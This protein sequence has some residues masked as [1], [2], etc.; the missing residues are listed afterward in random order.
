MGIL[1][2]TPDSF[3][4]GGKYYS[5]EDAFMHAAELE[6]EGADII[7][8]GGESSRP[9]AVPVCAQEEI[10]RILPVLIRIKKNLNIKVS[11]DTVKAE[12]AEHC[13]NEGADIINDISG[14]M[15]DKKMPEVVS[16]FGCEA[17]LMHMKGTPENMQN[18]VFYEN[19]IEEI[20]FSLDKSVETALA[21]GIKKERIIIDPGIGFGKEVKHNYEIINSIGEFKKSGL[22][23]LIGLSQ[24][25]LI[26]KLYEDKSIDRLP[27]T[28]ALNMISIY[29]GA[30]II[31]VHDVKQHRLALDAVEYL[32]ETG[33]L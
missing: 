11:I 5:A 19:L 3:H 10:D 18:N 16:R 9:G 2:V 31:R 20:R 12:V 27:A 14:F 28:I 21:A 7:D 13:L 25:S 32:M 30:D 1:N 8:I 17:V 4:D 33:V 29:N 26:W 23:V 22:R 6:K 15:H 24:K